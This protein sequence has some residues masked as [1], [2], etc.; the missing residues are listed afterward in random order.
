MK[1]FAESKTR[2]E[3]HLT[4]ISA[5]TTMLPWLT[6]EAENTIAEMGPDY[7]PY[8]V[9]KNRKTIEAQLRRAY[10]QGM[11]KTLWK[12]EEMFHPSTLTWYR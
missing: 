4:E 12:V 10:E 2:I 9:D 8:G 3:P 5:L 1:A 7:W 6:A 11:S